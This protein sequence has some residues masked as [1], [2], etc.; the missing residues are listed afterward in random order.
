M[1]TLEEPRTFPSPHRLSSEERRVRGEWKRFG[2]A[3]NMGFL[4]PRT[5]EFEWDANEP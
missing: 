1:Q 4:Q 5:E 3:P 2:G